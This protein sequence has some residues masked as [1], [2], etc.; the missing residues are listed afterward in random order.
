MSGLPFSPKRL[1]IHGVTYTLDVGATVASIGR[2]VLYRHLLP[3][4]L[5]IGMANFNAKI[6]GNSVSGMT[7][8]QALLANAS[9]N[10]A[11]VNTP[12]YT[13]REIDI[14]TRVDPATI[15]GIMR[16]GSGV[17]LGQIRR[18]TN[19]FLETSLR[20][21]VARQGQAEVRNDY[22]AR[23]ENA[24]S[25]TGPQM[26]IGSS[27]NDFFSSVNQLGVNPSSL[28]LRLNVLQRGEDLITTIR[29]SYEEIANAQAELDQR[30]SLE[31]S[32]IN[33]LSKEIAKLNTLIASRE[34][35]GISAVDER[36]QRDTVLA[37]L[38]EKI[39]YTTVET[40]N[41]MINC[42]LDNGFPLVNQEQARELSTTTT[43]S[44]A[45]GPLPKSLSDGV[46]SYV[47]YNFGTEAEPSHL[48]LTRMI[49][50]G[51]GSLSGVLQ[52]RG[53]AD[54]TNTSP[55]QADGDL[56]DMASR[57]EVLTRTLLTSVNQIY[58]GADEDGVT[59]GFQPSSADLN[60]NPPGVF[61][62]FDF[63]F[64]GVKDADGDGIAS[65]SDLAASGIS[66]FSRVL[67]L[68]F[69]SADEFAAS[70]D[71]NPAD[72]ATSFPSG[73]AQNA[74]AIAGLRTDVFSFSLDGFSFTG[75]FDELYNSSV[76]T[77]GDLK[78][79][80]QIA[81]DVSRAT[82]L[83]ASTKRDEFSSVNLDEEFANV[84][85]YQ[86]AFQAS[87]RMIRTASELIDTI[88]SLL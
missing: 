42:C 75:T 77:I 60:G 2:D 80:A 30:V 57:I 59:P 47:V 40:P 74:F 38:A 22:L 27:L 14:Q 71:N 50:N 39:S 32:S 79:A 82:Y 52:L 11:N 73:D 49:K 7:A 10:I 35:V 46:L 23:I 29:S 13:R 26:T 53:Y 45:T 36:D 8:Q 6:L 67:K 76:S 55:F 28:D 25:L 16:I 72:G 85:K 37:K 17:Q 9:N 62:L 88:V 19:T 48:D 63:D 12:G 15:D 70:R 84:I 51:Q 54:P 24:F 61:G 43:P 41:G 78:S 69:S 68:G 20:T 81:L 64:S 83:S 56:V 18:L 3:T 58:R 44:F 65:A 4:S 1:I 86:K 87:A 31:V 66:S 34:A 5:R 33:A 21:A